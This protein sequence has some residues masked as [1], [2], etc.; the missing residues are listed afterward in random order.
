VTTL[1]DEPVN[2][3]E[4]RYQ[5]RSD[6]INI[7]RPHIPGNQDTG[8]VSGNQQTF[9]CATPGQDLRIRS[10]FQPNILGVLHVVTART[11]QRA[12]STRQVL[13]DEQLQAG[14]LRGT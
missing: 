12:E 5:D 1:G 3:R 10:F 11:Q 7:Q 8:T 6:V 4:V 9:F 13:V 14:S 2:L